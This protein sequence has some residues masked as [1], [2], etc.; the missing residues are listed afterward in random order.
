MADE[1]NAMDTSEGGSRSCA[2][3]VLTNSFFVFLEGFSQN[4]LHQLHV[5]YDQSFNKGVFAFKTST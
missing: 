3:K 1:N 2:G 4:Y 5:A